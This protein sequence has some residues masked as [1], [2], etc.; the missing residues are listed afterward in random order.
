[1]N[2]NKN[3]SKRIFGNERKYI[4]EVIESGFR[5]STSAKMLNS[6]ETSFAKTF[7]V[8]HAIGFVNGTATMHA[9]LEAWGIGSGDEVIVPPLT[10]AATSFAVLQANATPVFADVDLKTFQIS[11]D[12]IEKNITTKTKA[13]IT[14]SLFGLSPDMDKIMSLA[15]KYE[16][17][18]LEDN[19]ECYLA[20]YNNKLVGTFGDCASYSFQN[21]KHIT[22]G[23]GGMIITNDIDFAD[24]LRKVQSL[25][26]ANVS[27]KSGKI[28]K[29][30]IQD[31]NYNRHVTLGWNYRMPELCCAV[32]LGQTENIS[33]L[34]NRR[35]EV[36]KLFYDSSSSYH[37]WFVPQFIPSNCDSSFWTWAVVLKRDDINFKIFRDR[38]KSLGGD[39]IYAAWKLT[40]EEP[41]FEKLKFLNRENFIS[42]NNLKKYKN[43]PCPNAKFL[44][45][46][47]LCFKTNYW[48]WSDAINQSNILKET[49]KSFG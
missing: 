38:F 2:K 17:K 36:A 45:P 13:I 4:D 10:M 14:V 30:T 19:A 29:D 8:D 18:V 49:L 33:N 16:L 40:Y 21:S 37:D 23:E 27:A 9:S 35:I 31:P 39:G 48:D 15:K 22:S 32:A 7:G 20:K 46:K 47:L 11:S 44:Q 6:L 12:S 41:A 42:P 5:A 26:Y 24:K 28:T 3:F 43:N 1:M 34:V 25:G